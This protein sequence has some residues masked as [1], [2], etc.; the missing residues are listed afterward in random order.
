MLLLLAAALAWLPTFGA[1]QTAEFAF[2]TDAAE[3]VVIIAEKLDGR[4]ACYTAISTAEPR[5]Y[6]RD[7]RTGDWQGRGWP[8]RVSVRQDGDWIRATV[9]FEAEYSG[10]RSIYVQERPGPGRWYRAGVWEITRDDLAA[11]PPSLP[12]QLPARQAA[13]IARRLARAD[14]GTYPAAELV[15]RNGILQLAGWDYDVR[16]GRLVPRIDWPDDDTVS[17]I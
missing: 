16:E 8:C 10:R 13:R 17:T 14:D 1:G 2:R 6:S 4:Q 7:A 12:E 5:A 9:E 11:V 3:L 15:F